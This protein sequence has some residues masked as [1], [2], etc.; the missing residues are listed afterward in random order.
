MSAI[1]IDQ[2]HVTELALHPRFRQ[3]GPANILAQ[4]PIP[5]GSSPITDLSDELLLS[6]FKR[7]LDLRYLSGTCP[8]FARIASDVTLIDAKL[9]ALNPLIKSCST[10]YYY[11]KEQEWRVDT[12][13]SRLA[14]LPN[15][16][17]YPVDGGAPTIPLMQA[18]FQKLMDK[19]IE[20][21]NP[22]SNPLTKKIGCV[23]DRLSPLDQKRFL[24][25]LPVCLYTAELPLHPRFRQA[26]P[27][28]IPAQTPIPDGSSLITALGDEIW[29]RIFERNDLDLRYLSGTC[30]LF[31]RI[32]SDVTLVDAKLQALN[33]LIESCSTEHRS[34]AQEW[35]VDTIFFH[36][37][38]LPNSVL[39]PVDG[40]PTIPLMQAMFQKLMGK[41][42]G[43]PFTLLT[44]KIG[45]V[46]LDRLSLLNQRRFVRNLPTPLMR[47]F[48]TPCIIEVNQ[49]LSR[50][51]ISNDEMKDP[52]GIFYFLLNEKSYFSS[53]IHNIR[54]IVEFA[55]P[56]ILE[57]LLDKGARSFYN[58][59]V[60]KTLIGMRDQEDALKK[61]FILARGLEKTY[62]KAQPGEQFLAFEFLM[63]AV[64]HFS[65]TQPEKFTDEIIESCLPL[66]FLTMGNDVDRLTALA[67]FVP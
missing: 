28:N 9:Q 41:I 60:A 66:R 3:A 10:D 29:L 51:L 14:R 39:Y 19:I 50:G 64:Q 52:N 34:K 63:E 55:S 61:L 17:L 43:L 62:E 16:V 22:Y 46:V 1:N 27:A 11:P 36:L 4:T 45:Y 24:R 53:L 2:S 48:K 44:R 58:S 38:R 26:G 30:P 32:A 37:A 47:F 31:A 56:E 7:N 35:R 8:L 13:F 49:R 59:T 5:D 18:M 33:P 57:F 21:E 54:I 6:I 25:N 15:S 23:L 40:A 42:K 20:I 65:N 12:I 67:V